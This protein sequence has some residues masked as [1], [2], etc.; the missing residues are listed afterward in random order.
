MVIFNFPLPK[1]TFANFDSQLTNIGWETGDLSGWEKG[2]VVDSIEVTTGDQF[3]YPYSGDYM[4]KLGTMVNSSSV[5][6][7]MG[8]NLLY[9]DFVVNSNELTFYYNL[10]TYDY[11]GYDEFTYDLI[12]LDTGES[13]ISYSQDAWGPSGDITLKNTGWQKVTVNLSE[14]QG[15]KIRI[16]FNVAGTKDNLYATWGYIDFKEL[17]ENNGSIIINEVNTPTTVTE[18]DVYETYTISLSSKPD[19]DVIINIS[20]DADTQLE[21]SPDLLVFTPENW[22]EPQTIELTAVDDSVYEGNHYAKLVHST[23]SNDKKFN[24][25][26]DNLTVYIIDNNQPKQGQYSVIANVS[27][28]LGTVVPASQTIASGESAIVELKPEEDFIP[29]VMD[30]GENVT[31]LVKDNQY[32]IDSVNTYHN[33]VVTFVPKTP[34][35]ILYTDPTNLDTNIPLDKKISVIFSDEIKAGTE[36]ENIV[37]KDKDGNIISTNISINSNK[38]LIEPKALLESDTLYE[39]VIP[40]NSVLDS[41]DIG[42]KNNYIFG[43]DTGNHQDDDEVV[44]QSLEFVESQVTMA[45]GESHAF[46]VYAVM[47]DGSKKDVTSESGTTYKR[48]SSYATVNNGTV[49]LS[50]STKLGIT[51]KITAQYEGLKA[52]VFIEVLNN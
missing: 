26:H 16:Q 29:Q 6:Q 45:P 51:I 3:T 11:T 17:D 23:S 44:L 31:H 25:I 50:N 21:F 24:N 27:S 2:T 41:Y 10:F 7:P 49:S 48:S 43:F 20:E 4:V 34:P 38:L 12:D 37:L 22:N 42:F 33:I 1:I 32:I 9:Q 39:V 30:N 8:D 52:E 28:G 19:S 47:S 40:K 14:Y 18:G 13:I 35:K 46:K 15:K 5:K 36:F